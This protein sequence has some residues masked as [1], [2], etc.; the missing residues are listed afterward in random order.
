MDDDQFSGRTLSPI[1]KSAIQLGNEK[2]THGS[3]INSKKKGESHEVKEA[4]VSSSF[5]EKDDHVRPS[6]PHFCDNL[7]PS[8]TCNYIYDD[9][10]TEYE[11]YWS[12]Q[13]VRK[14]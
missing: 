7:F 14:D 6:E 1:I 13:L 4:H 3:L 10:L 9:F 5:V 12:K 2:I 8:I 11:H